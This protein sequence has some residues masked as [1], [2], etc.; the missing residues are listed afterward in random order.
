MRHTFQSLFSVQ[1][2]KWIN[3]PDA[4]ISQVCYMSFKYRSTRFGYPHSHH[5]ELNC[6]ISLWF[7]VGTWWLKC[8]WSWSGRPRPTALLSP[9]SDGKPE[10]A[11]AVVELLMM[12]IKMPETCWAVLKRQV[13]NL[14]NCCVWLVE[15]FEYMIMHGLANP[16]FIFCIPFSRLLCPSFSEFFICR[17]VRHVLPVIQPVIYSLRHSVSSKIFRWRTHSLTQSLVHSFT[18]SRSHDS[19]THSLTHTRSHARTHSVTH[20]SSHP[21][22]L[23]QSLSLKF[24]PRSPCLVFNL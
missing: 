23:S 17:S 9:S 22:V 15:S 3:Q 21:Q 13:I 20:A 24:L 12:G 19:L 18:H 7:T 4:A 14:R 1:T 5:Q 10:A 11:T 6:S 2:F 16:K 8:C